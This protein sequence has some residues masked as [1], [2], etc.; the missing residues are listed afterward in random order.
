MVRLEE[1]EDPLDRHGARL[2]TV[3]RTN[4]H[5]EWNELS[6]TDDFFQRHLQ[7][8]DLIEQVRLMA[9]ALKRL[10]ETGARDDLFRPER[11]AHALPHNRMLSLLGWEEDEY[12]LRLYCLRWSDEI[13]ILINGGCKTAQT[14]Q[15]CPNVRSHFN[16]A[17]E[18]ARL[19]DRMN[20]EDDL[21]VNQNRLTLWDGH[22]VE[23]DI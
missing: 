13:V 14:A 7:H 19:L 2:Y 5:G 1:Y 18:V 16:F 21:K 11:E 3:R 23:L 8:E 6:E 10:R 20:R 17:N 22:I 12:C 4:E 15:E 9:L